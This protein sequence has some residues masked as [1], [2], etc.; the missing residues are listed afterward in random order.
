MQELRDVRAACLGPWLVLGDFN[1]TARTEDKNNGLANKAMMGRFRS[2][3]NDLELKDLPLLGRKYTW[4]N[5][6]DSLTDRVLCSADWEQ[7]FPNFLLQ[8]SATDG[9]DNCPLLDE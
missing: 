3:I 2:L 1:L 9:S 7:L 6:Q 4:S 8:S 5:Q